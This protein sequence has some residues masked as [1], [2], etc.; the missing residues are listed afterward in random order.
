MTEIQDSGRIYAAEYAARINRVMDYI[1]MHLP[2]ALSLEELAEVAGFSKY[3][4]HRM[5][6]A[7]TGETLFDYIQRLRLEKSASLLLLNPG[8]TVTEVALEYGFSSSSVFARAFRA[9]FGVSATQWRSQK[10]SPEPESCLTERNSKE[11]KAE[12]SSSQM[13]RNNRKDCRFPSRYI[14]Y[15]AHSH[16]WRVPMNNNLTQTVEV[17]DLPDMTVAYFRYVGPYQ[18]DSQLFER[19]H[20]TLHQWA[21]PRGLVRYPETQSL[22]I[23]HD[24]PEITDENKLRISVC[25]TVPEDTQI[26]GEVGKL[27]IPAGRYA[28]ARYVLGA[29]EFQQAWSWVYGEWLPASG[30]TTDDRPCFEWYHGSPEDH[31]EGKFTLD[32]CV[33]V[34]PL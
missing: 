32:I 30:Y 8:L 28:L 27:T 33:P 24:S 15:A 25:L 4:F 9:C 17:K 22:V 1:E 10:V 14:E 26:S 18:G 12:S 11:S 21:G 7:Y 20:G 6:H 23:Y 3:H 16:I 29:D 13:N 19:L 31:P 34:R 2:D 5:F